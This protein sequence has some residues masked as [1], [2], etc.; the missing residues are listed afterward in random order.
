MRILGKIITKLIAWIPVYFCLLVLALPAY[1][2]F[3]QGTAIIPV[4]KSDAKYQRLI[5]SEK[6]KVNWGSGTNIS[7]PRNNIYIRWAIAKFPDLISCGDGKSELDWK[8]IKTKEQLLLCLHYLLAKQKN[9]Y[10]FIKWLETLNIDYSTRKISAFTSEDG[11]LPT[12]Q[13][14]IRFSTTY[15]ENSK[16]SE[17]PRPFEVIWRLSGGTSGVEVIFDQSSQYASISKWSESPIN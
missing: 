5:S 13:I 7:P 15:Q 3:L 12:G 17:M 1:L 2:L 14:G 9:I 10:V 6:P 8:G 11:Y 4:S 16:I